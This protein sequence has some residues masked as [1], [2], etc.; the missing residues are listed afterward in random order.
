MKA[1]KNKIVAFC[2][3]IIKI[4]LCENGFSQAILVYL[5]CLKI[6]CKIKCGHF[7]NQ[8]TRSNEVDFCPEVRQ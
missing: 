4:V 3:K 1:I 5:H 6:T 2:L 8:I 7:S